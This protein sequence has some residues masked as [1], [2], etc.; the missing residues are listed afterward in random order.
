[1]T[2]R[3]LL[4]LSVVF[5]AAF[6]AFIFFGRDI[7]SP[8][9]I[10][11]AGAV[12]LGARLFLLPRGASP[13]TTIAVMAGTAVLALAAVTGWGTYA[14]LYPTVVNA[15]LMIVFGLTL[16]SPPSLAERLARLRGEPV[17]ARGVVYTKWVTA[18]WTIFFFCNGTIAGILALRGDL[19][20]WAF[21]TGIL[22]YVLAAVLMGS[23]L[24]FR[25]FYKA[26]V[27]SRTENLDCLP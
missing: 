20:A 18:M 26:R 22:G 13:G 19:A 27:L 17:S 10:A 25:R 24:L 12:I 4:V 5:T 2:G 16:W 14:L 21:Y 8:A 23:E 6:P 11:L 15:G 3:A 7:V 9:A 1:V